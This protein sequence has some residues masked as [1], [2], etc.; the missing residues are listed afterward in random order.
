M[1]GLRPFGDVENPDVRN[2]ANRKGYGQKTLT[3]HVKIF[4]RELDK[5]VIAKLP[6]KFGLVFD[7]WSVEHRH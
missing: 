2:F 1:T 3:K 4:R 5:I 6:F 7:E